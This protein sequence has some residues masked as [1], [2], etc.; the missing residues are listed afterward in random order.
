MRC[1]LIGLCLLSMAGCAMSD[2]STSSNAS[3]GA[4]WAIVIHGG[5]GA[6]SRD[7]SPEDVAGYRAAL[8]EALEAGRA[9]LESGGQSLDAVETAIRVM[10]DNPRFNAGKGA[11]MTATGAHELDASIMD[12]ATRAAGAVAGVRTI[13]NPI[14]L[15]RLVMTQTPHVLLGG[16]GADQFGAAM[17]VEQVDQ[18]YFYTE[19]RHNQLKRAQQKNQVSLDHDIKVDPIPDAQTDTPT[20]PDFDENK[21]GTVGCVVLDIHGN[22]AAGTSTGGMTNKKHGRIGD[23]PIVGAGTYADNNTCAVSGTGWGEQFI[24]NGVAFQISAIMEHRRVSLAEAARIVIHEK[25]NKGDGGIIAVDGAGNIVM[26]YN[27]PGM[28]RGAADASGRFE[29]AIWEN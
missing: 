22:L 6:I 11:V 28:Y 26:D 14:A 20:Q 10:E 4:R 27:S 18:K 25:L 3:G 1:V 23:S 16:E 13:K 5:A 12:G 17:G 29:I 21:Y 24:R 7:A 9:L 19:R 8:T 15:A 2:K